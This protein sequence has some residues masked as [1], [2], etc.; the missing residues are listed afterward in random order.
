MCNSLNWDLFD[1]C[2]STPK[3]MNDIIKYKISNK[4]TV[5]NPSIIV[6]ED[7]DLLLL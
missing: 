3:T 6:L 1:Y 7:T 5:I 4:E 2:I